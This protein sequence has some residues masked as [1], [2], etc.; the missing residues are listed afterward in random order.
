MRFTWPLTGRAGDLRRIEAALSCPDWRGIVISGTAGV[1]KS[2]IA[3]EAL[4]TARSTA[5]DVRWAF[6][7]TSARAIPLGA[8][9]SWENLAGNDTGVLVHSVINARTSPILG[10]V[11]LG[12]DDVHLLDA[13]SAF[14]LHQIVKRRA[15]KVVLT[16]RDGEPVPPEIEQLWQADTFDRLELKPLAGNDIA[17]LL[18]ATLGGSVDPEVTSRL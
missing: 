9:A 13:L 8:F 12:V 16:V 10:C 17:S 15:A 1:G 7:T 2:R 4:S 3:R 6:G 14:V 11:V 5:W 18:S